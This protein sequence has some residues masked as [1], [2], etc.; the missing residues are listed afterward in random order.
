MSGR[1]VGIGPLALAAACGLLALGAPAWAEDGVRLVAV[2][3]RDTRYQYSPSL[4]WDPE[5]GLFKMWFCG[6]GESAGNGDVIYYAVSRDGRSWSEPVRVL[7]PDPGQ[8]DAMYVCDPSVVKGV[9]PGW[10]YTMYY[11]GTDDI[12][13]TDNGFGAAFSQDGVHW[14]RWPGNPIRRHTGSPDWYGVGM[15]TAIQIGDTPRVY[16]NLADETGIRVYRAVDLGDGV[17][18]AGDA[19]TEFTL[20]TQDLVYLPDAGG[21]LVAF[22]NGLREVTVAYSADCVGV[23]ERLWTVGPDATGA[24]DNHNPGFVRDPAGGW[25]GPDVRVLFASGDAWG[26][27]QFRFFLEAA[28]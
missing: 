23:T 21:C 12:R 2:S 1:R 20:Q 16:W 5:D 22:D 13:G 8:W 28:P 24:R 18:L 25:P 17:T 7:E 27:W 3:I 6:F 10:A 15:P 9:T 19:P 4:M 14:V 11:T 26:D